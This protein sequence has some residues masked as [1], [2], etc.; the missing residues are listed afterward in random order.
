MDLQDP[1]K[2]MS[3]SSDNP[4]SFILIMDPPDVIRKKISRAVTDSLGVVNY[5]DEQPGV[6]NL[7]NILSA[8]KGVNPENL[9]A[10]YEG[11]GYAELKQDVAEAIVGELSPI[12]DKVKELLADKTYLESIYKQGAEKANYIANKVLRKMQKKIGFIPR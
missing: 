8:I 11:K 10:S 12:Q 1:T 9:V 5:T 7:L 6:K 4:N 2:K 3:K